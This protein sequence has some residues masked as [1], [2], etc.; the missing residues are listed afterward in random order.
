MCERGLTLNTVCVCV[1]VDAV[2]FIRC[3]PAIHEGRILAEA[4]PVGF[5]IVDL[6]CCGSRFSPSDCADHRHC[7][8]SVQEKA[9]EGK[10]KKCM[11][12]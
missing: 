2:P 9:K 10:K 4:R 11:C 12:V 3:K 7:V 5:G 8:S 6:G 1:P